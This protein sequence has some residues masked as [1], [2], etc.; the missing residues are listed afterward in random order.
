MAASSRALSTIQLH[1][2]TRDLVVLCNKKNK[3]GQD[4]TI[5]Y[6]F[7]VGLYFLHVQTPLGVYGG[8]ITWREGYFGSNL[9]HQQC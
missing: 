3:D 8:T 4:T 2:K 6:V 7:H 5:K 9:H 1:E